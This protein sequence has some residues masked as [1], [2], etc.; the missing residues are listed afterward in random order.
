MFT[1]YPRIV[2]TSYVLASFVSL[3]SIYQ[4]SGILEK[5]STNTLSRLQI[6]F[7]DKHFFFFQFHANHSLKSKLMFEHNLALILAYVLV[8]DEICVLD[9]S[10]L[11]L[12][13]L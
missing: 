8:K 4:K 7:L 13:S 11:L 10:K 6:H 12:L 9:K 5:M 1:W 2:G 3:Y